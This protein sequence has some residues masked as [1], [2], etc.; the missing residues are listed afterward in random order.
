MLLSTFAGAADT[1]ALE[2]PSISMEQAIAAAKQHVQVQNF[3]ISKHYL[4]SAE[5]HPRS[6]LISFWRIE[7]R[8]KQPVKGGQIFVTIDSKGKIEHSFGE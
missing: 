3:D 7:W 1:G 4:A 8:M 5:W 6:G 2:T